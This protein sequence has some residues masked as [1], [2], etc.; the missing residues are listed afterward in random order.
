VEIESLK[1]RLSV[2]VNE[3]TVQNVTVLQQSDKIKEL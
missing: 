2:K 1:E 3:M